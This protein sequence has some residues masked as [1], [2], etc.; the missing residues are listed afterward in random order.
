M[1][2]FLSAM[3]TLL[4]LCSLASL[5]LAQTRERDPMT[6]AEVDQM[7]E[8]ADYPDKRLELMI[9]FSRERLAMIDLLR[10][11]PATPTRPK[12]IHD[13]LQD[14]MMLLDETD[15]NVDMYASHNADM[16]KGLKLLIEADSE[17]QLKLRQIK[18]QSPPDELQQYAFVLTD[19]ADAVGDSAKN[20]RET[21]QEQNKLAAE[22]KLI[23]DY[24]E[25]KD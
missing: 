5:S 12:Q 3:A 22:K 24:S 7:R 16:R 17:W 25:R 6:D 23:K 15:D 21:L 10:T 9:R 18:E 20:A 1:K 13:L 11:D 4:L 14:F 2:C 8:A 19:A